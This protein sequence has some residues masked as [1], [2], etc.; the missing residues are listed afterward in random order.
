MEFNFVDSVK[1]AFP[2]AHTCDNTI[3]LPGLLYTDGR[4]G[5]ENKLEEAVMIYGARFNTS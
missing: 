2:V 1:D 3:K 5:F 4:K